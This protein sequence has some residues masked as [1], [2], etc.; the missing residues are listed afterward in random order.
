MRYVLASMVAL[1]L[2]SAA[3]LARA[4]VTLWQGAESGMSHAEVRQAFDVV[5]GSADRLKNGATADLVIPRYAAAGSP[6]KVIF[7]FKDGGLKQVTL[8]HRQPETVTYPQVESLRDILSGKY[9]TPI[10]FQRKNQFDDYVSG[11]WKDGERNVALIWIAFGSSS[12]L[13]INYQTRLSEAGEKF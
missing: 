12:V 1:V 9:G 8:S 4:G 10:S 11:Q 3:G 13:N 2:L 6:F 5:E 7:Y